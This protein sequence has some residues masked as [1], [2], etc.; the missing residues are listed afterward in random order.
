MASFSLD[1]LG[2]GVSPA[3]LEQRV[4]QQTGL[5]VIGLGVV[6]SNTNPQ[7]RRRWEALVRAGVSLEGR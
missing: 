6:P 1:L 5:Q 4:V 2:L 7:A 3:E